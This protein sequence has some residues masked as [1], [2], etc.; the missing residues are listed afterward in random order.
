V[1]SQQVKRLTFTRVHNLSQLHD[2]L[3]AAIPALRPLNGVPQITV[4]GKDNSIRLTVADNADDAA[5]TAVVNNHTPAP[6]PAPADLKQ[7]A[8]DFRQAVNQANTLA[9]LK[10]AINQKLMPLLKEALISRERDL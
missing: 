3:L 1:E 9:Q 6:P 10:L 2:E 4:E 5:I 7:L 8:Q